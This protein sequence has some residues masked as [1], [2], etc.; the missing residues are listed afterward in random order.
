MARCVCVCVCVRVLVTQSCPA[1]RKP[2][3]CSPP[4]SSVYGFSQARIL[5]LDAI[6]FSRESSWKWKWSRSVVSDSLWPHGQKPTRLCRPWDFP[7]KNTGVGCHF[8]LQGIFPTQGLN[9][10]LLH[11]RQTLYHLSHQ[12]R[13]QTQVS[14]IAGR[15]LTIWATREAP[16]ARWAVGKSQLLPAGAICWVSIRLGCEGNGALVPTM[17]AVDTVGRAAN[18][19]LVNE[20]FHSAENSQ[21]CGRVAAATLSRSPRKALKLWILHIFL[22]PT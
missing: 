11:C 5:E 16:M 8:L 17:L 20:N 18:I 9:P 1:L 7:G 12:G 14:C 4:G 6:S 13:D 22:T 10:G 15:V 2:I 19:W 21:I 3:D